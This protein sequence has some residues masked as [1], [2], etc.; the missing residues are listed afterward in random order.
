MRPLVAQGLSAAVYTQTSDVEG[1]INGLMTY[2]REVIKLP[3]AKT[4]ASNKSVASAKTF[5]D[6]FQPMPIT[7][8]LTH[9]EP[10]NER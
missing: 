8:S 1:E 10:N 2:D 7:D 9:T 3:V 4:A 6:N 5:I